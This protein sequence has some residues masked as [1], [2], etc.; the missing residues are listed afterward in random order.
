MPVVV[1]GT[2]QCERFE[3]SMRLNVSYGR[4]GLMPEATL[5]RLHILQFGL[6]VIGVDIILCIHPANLLNMLRPTRPC[7]CVTSFR[8]DELA[9]I[10]RSSSTHYRYTHLYQYVSV[11]STSHSF[12]SLPCHT[13]TTGIFVN[14]THLCSILG[15]LD[16]NKLTKDMARNVNHSHQGSPTVAEVFVSPWIDWL[17]V[18]AKL[19]RLYPVTEAFTLCCKVFRRHHIIHTFKQASPLIRG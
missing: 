9:V 13:L 8:E 5:C 10:H 3:Q 1:T 14:Q 17:V 4:V 7:A 16:D 2:V 11:P 12:H 19:S 6:R 15:G 18:L